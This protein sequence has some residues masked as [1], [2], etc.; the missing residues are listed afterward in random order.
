MLDVFF[1]KINI[2]RLD[3][4]F[5]AFWHRVARIHRKVQNYLLNLTGISFDASEIG[6]KRG[7]QID[8]FSYETTQHL[9]HLGY[10]GLEIEDFRLQDLSATESQELTGQRRSTVAGLLYLFKVRQQWIFRL[11]TTHSERAEPSDNREE[12]VEIMSDPAG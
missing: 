5:S 3:G 1:V 12:I 10:D 9:L 8:V 6:L 7:A 2:A 11:Q 4:E